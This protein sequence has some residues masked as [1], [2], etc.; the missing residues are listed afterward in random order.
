MQTFALYRFAFF[1][2][3]YTNTSYFLFN[4]LPVQYHL[5]AAEI[6]S[7]ISILQV[8]HQRRRQAVALEQ[9]RCVSVFDAATLCRCGVWHVN[10]SASYS[11][12]EQAG[13]SGLRSRRRG[14]RSRP[15]HTGSSSS[16]LTDCRV[17]NV[18]TGCRKACRL[19]TPLSPPLL[20]LAPW[21][22]SLLIHQSAPGQSGELGAG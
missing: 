10:I 12:S 4:N 8:T 11:D 1:L 20:S 6:N 3:Q 13:D 21:V 22:L 15:G 19:T 7:L 16:P 9:L 17:V 18:Y 2:F 14:V 5:P